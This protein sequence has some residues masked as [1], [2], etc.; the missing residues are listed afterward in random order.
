MK[1]RLFTLLI[2]LS[3]IFKVSATDIPK[4]WLKGVQEGDTSCVHL[5]AHHYA[6]DQN[7]GSKA[8]QWLRRSIDLKGTGGLESQT[9]LAGYYWDGLGVKKDQNKAL[10]LLKEA[11]EE[12]YPYAALA[13]GYIYKNYLHEDGEAIDWLYKAHI[14]ATEQEYFD[15]GLKDLYMWHG[16]TFLT[17]KDRE[18]GMTFIR[19]Y[20]LLE[21][22]AHNHNKWAYRYLGD[23]FLRYM[24]VHNF[25]QGILYYEQA[26]LLG[27]EES[28][29][30][31]GITTG[32]DGNTGYAE[33]GRVFY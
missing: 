29:T 12:G 14:M 31:V 13:L 21:E 7:H 16:W 11:A 32:Q 9:T 23:I 28:K 1:S 33:I 26:A 4:S 20:N 18:N 25:K 10:V 5:I 27:D 8:L 22:I 3:V 15:F 17:K 2:A 6:H 19:A 30:F 24:P